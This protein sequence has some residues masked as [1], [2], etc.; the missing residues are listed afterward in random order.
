MMAKSRLKLKGLEGRRHS[1]HRLHVKGENSKEDGLEQ[2]A[3]R[4]RHCT[5]CG[6]KAESELLCEHT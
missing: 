4:G 3:W 6:S 2:L 5:K 1:K